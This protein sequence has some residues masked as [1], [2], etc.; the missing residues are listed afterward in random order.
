M[1]DRHSAITPT[2]SIDSTMYAIAPS[3]RTTRSSGVSAVPDNDVT[4]PGCPTAAGCPNPNR[5]VPTRYDVSTINTIVISTN[6]AMPTNFAAS[7]RVLPTGRTSRYRSVPLVASPATASPANIATATGR[8]IGSTSASAAAGNSEP[9]RSTAD[10]NA[11]PCPGGGVRCV[12]A[13]KTATTAGSAHNSRTL[14]HILGRRNR[15]RSSTRI[16]AA[17]PRPPARRPDR[18]PARG[19][20]GRCRRR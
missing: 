16:T 2:P 20:P 5:P 11:A 19:R 6:T 15:V 7:S 4:P 17:H 9:S 1:V 10:R 8:K 13:R 12:V 18:R 3:N 14:T